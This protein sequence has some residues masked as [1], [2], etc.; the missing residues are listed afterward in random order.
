MTSDPQ[1]QEI[2]QIINQ[3]ASLKYNW[4]SNDF[5]L[6]K[7]KKEINSILDKN[8]ND[9]AFCHMALAI[10]NHHLGKNIEA[11]QCAKNSLLLSPNNQMT[12]QNYIIFCSS[13]GEIRES[14]KSVDELMRKFPNIKSALACAIIQS[15]C[16]LQVASYFKY[17]DLYSKLMVNEEMISYPGLFESMTILQKTFEDRNISQDH[18]L[19]LI[20]TASKAV[21]SS[22]VAILNTNTMTLLNGTAIYYFYIDAEMKVCSEMDWVI[23][24]ALVDTFDDSGMDYLSI[25]CRPIKDFDSS[26]HALGF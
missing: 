23:A 22:G 5:L 16:T 14:K 7:L 19:D 10:V 8:T 26:L 9:P 2:T 13:G 15:A 3:L 25:A 20:D 18:V 24:E 12:L 6:L 1:K 21:A 11:I 17:Q 4:G